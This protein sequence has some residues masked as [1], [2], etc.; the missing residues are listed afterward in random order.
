MKDLIEY[1]A[2][3]LVDNPEG[4]QVKEHRGEYVIRVQLQV[5]DDDKGKVIGREGKIAR[6]LRTIVNATASREGKRGILEIE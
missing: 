4:V 1:I 5:D 6:A 2:R 3:N